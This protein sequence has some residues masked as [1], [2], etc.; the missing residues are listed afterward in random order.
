MTKLKRSA[1][2]GVVRTIENNC[3]LKWNGIFETSGSNSVFPKT[4]CVLRWFVVGAI[5]QYYESRRAH[6]L[7]GLP[8]RREKVEKRQKEKNADF[9]TKT[10]GQHFSD[11]N[12]TNYKLS[13]LDCD[14][15]CQRIEN[16]YP[17]LILLSSCS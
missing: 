6:Y 13:N 11:R 17:F 4:Q 16:S 1:V 8:G 9:T 2:C 12:I 3:H 10:G 5:R 7:D 15:C 14:T